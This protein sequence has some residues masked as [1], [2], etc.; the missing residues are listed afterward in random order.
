[1]EIKFPISNI[2]DFDALLRSTEAAMTKAAKSPPSELVPVKSKA[3]GF[4]MKLQRVGAQD[5]YH[6]IKR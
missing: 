1:M 3:G 5:L 6:F 4:E 2:A